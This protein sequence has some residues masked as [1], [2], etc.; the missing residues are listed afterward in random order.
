M[1]HAR[2]VRTEPVEPSSNSRKIER[3]F[4]ALC[5]SAQTNEFPSDYIKTFL[6][7]DLRRD[8]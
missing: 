5:V 6:K 4:F 8:R 7:N 3:D 2:G 1:G